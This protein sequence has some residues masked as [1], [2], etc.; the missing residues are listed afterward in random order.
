MERKAKGRSE[1]PLGASGEFLRARPMSE[2][3]RKTHDGG[4]LVLDFTEFDDSQRRDASRPPPGYN[5]EE[6]DTARY[7]YINSV[8]ELR[9]MLQGAVAFSR[10]D[11]D[12]AAFAERITAIGMCT[13]DGEEEHPYY[14]IEDTVGMQFRLYI[15]P[16]GK[17]SSAKVQQEKRVVLDFGGRMGYLFPLAFQDEERSR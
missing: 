6:P 13:R 4:M 1:S 15:D 17:V 12:A 14:T 10:T 5:E 2:P 8:P 9:R 11:F 7:S 16:L 3:V